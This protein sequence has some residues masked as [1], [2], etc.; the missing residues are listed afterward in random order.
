MTIGMIAL[1]GERKLLPV[2]PQTI[3]MIAL[4]R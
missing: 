3:G 4:V 1:L 2:Q